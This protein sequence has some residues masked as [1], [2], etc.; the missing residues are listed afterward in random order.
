MEDSLRLLAMRIILLE[1]LFFGDAEPAC[2][3]TVVGSSGRVYGPVDLIVLA[4]A[5]GQ[6]KSAW[7]QRTFLNADSEYLCR[8]LAALT[9]RVNALEVLTGITPAE[10]WLPSAGPE[11]GVDG[12]A[13]PTLSSAAAGIIGAGIDALTHHVK[14]LET[15]TTAP[16]SVPTPTP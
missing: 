16:G 5:C 3:S 12:G 2:R 13:D 6:R 15:L 11:C 10:D 7:S 9:S 4:A 1:V 14:L 8:L